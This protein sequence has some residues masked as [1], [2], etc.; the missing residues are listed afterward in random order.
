MEVVVKD[1]N[2]ELQYATEI[3]FENVTLHHWNSISPG[4]PFLV[5][6]ILSVLAENQTHE[7]ATNSSQNKLKLVNS[8]FNNSSLAGRLSFIESESNTDAMSLTSS[9]LNL[10]KMLILL[11]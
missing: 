6:Q 8:V 9:T 3:R 1:V 2:I 5:F 7:H 4:S 11:S 10:G